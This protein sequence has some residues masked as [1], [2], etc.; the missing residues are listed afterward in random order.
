MSR[1]YGDN[2]GTAPDDGYAYSQLNKALSQSRRQRLAAA[3]AS[4][5]RRS[6]AARQA[7]LRADRCRVFASL[8]TLIQIFLIIG[9]AVVFFVLVKGINGGG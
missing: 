3:G 8:I 4:A 2:N 6:S 5:K 7:V 9:S 1:R